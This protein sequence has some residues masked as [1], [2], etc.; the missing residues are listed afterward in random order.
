M[1][2]MFFVDAMSLVGDR[3]EIVD[4]D[5]YRLDLNLNLQS[6]FYFQ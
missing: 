3:Y 6:Y 5:H 2:C 1:L 4:E